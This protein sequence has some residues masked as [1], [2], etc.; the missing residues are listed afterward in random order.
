MASNQEIKLK[1]LRHCRAVLELRRKIT[2]QVS[3]RGVLPVWK[4]LETTLHQHCSAMRAELEAMDHSLVSSM[5]NQILDTFT[6]PKEHLEK[7]IKFALEMS[8]AQASPITEEDIL[9]DLQ[10]LVVAFHNHTDHLLRVACIV[11]AWCTN[12]KSTDD[13]ENS[14]GHLKLIRASIVP[15]LAELCNSSQRAVGL[16]KLQTLYQTW[17][18]MTES[19]LV[20]FDD[21]FNLQQF[22]DVCVHRIEH[23]REQCERTLKSQQP[24]Q[25]SQHGDD[26]CAQANL[27]VQLISKYVERNQ[28]PIFRNGL[29]ALVK[30]IE[31]SIEQ[32]RKSKSCCQENPFDVTLGTL[33]LENIQHVTESV[34]NVR[35]GVDGSN[36]PD[37]L[38]PLR[39]HVRSQPKRCENPELGMLPLSH[40]GSNKQ[41]QAE[42][43][44]QFLEYLS[45]ALPPGD[46]PC[47]ETPLVRSSAPD[48]L[49]VNYNLMPV[50]RDIMAAAKKNDIKAVNSASSDLFE[51]SDIYIE[52][53]K[54]ALQIAHLQESCKLRKYA[55][56]QKQTSKFIHVCRGGAINSDLHVDQLLKIA[57]VLSDELAEITKSLVMVAG[58]WGGFCQQLF[59]TKATADFPSRIQIFKETNQNLSAVV[60]Q[61]GEVPHVDFGKQ[62]NT[63]PGIHETFLE[64][65]TKLAR[66]ETNAKHVLQTA[67]SYNDNPWC[68]GRI[69]ILE[70][71]C[72]L[73]SVCVQQLLKSL[74]KFTGED[75]Q[76][77][78]GSKQK[79]LA[80]ILESSLR[81]QETAKMSTQCCIDQTLKLRIN[82]LREQI[83]H[84]TQ[85]LLQT[86]EGCDMSI[87]SSINPVRMELLQRQIFLKVKA[88]MKMLQSTN[89]EYIGALQGIIDLVAAGGTAHGVDK[90][91]NIKVFEKHSN[92]INENI[93]RA[94]TSLKQ[95]FGTL[96]DL[97]SQESF[98]SMV[99]HLALLMSD[100]LGRARNILSGNHQAGTDMLKN[101]VSDWSARAHFL[102][103]RLEA[104]EGTDQGLLDLIKQCLQKSEAPSVLNADKTS[105]FH[106]EDQAA[107]KEVIKKDKK[108]QES[109]HSPSISEKDRQK[110]KSE[111]HKCF[112]EPLEVLKSSDMELPFEDQAVC[113]KDEAESEHDAWHPIVQVTKEMDKQ[114]SY[115]VQYLTKEGPIQVPLVYIFDVHANVIPPDI[116]F[117]HQKIILKKKIRDD[118]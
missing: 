100:F 18:R 108:T 113:V 65:Q 83:E 76:P 81:I 37:I 60:Y 75:I 71:K 82:Q 106:T 102:V 91:H 47:K 109:S 29:L 22:L 66:V 72:I 88:L 2:S 49:F 9:K 61:A 80:S 99:D 53:A 10:P 1:L 52:A 87:M 116:G 33:F 101:M 63:F 38:S 31:Q 57:I 5:L 117:H 48:D 14:M 42:D 98:I 114:M 64:I 11:L 43:N 23:N 90:E 79:R 59:C 74:D 112:D 25:F 68:T 16:E 41:D 44:N 62:I 3:A 56:I 84:L 46:C 7:L 20:S 17:T 69:D 86:T 103:T 70:A 19:L 104:V 78:T 95:T 39:E 58:I 6:H 40:V 94:K 32:A 8:V 30:Q 93:Q 118:L 96:I 27:V 26:L 111:R 36:H 92:Q 55:R 97:K 89:K 21:V 34:C 54:E 45:K 110:T 85:D 15:L 107:M 51:F 4:L 73:W 77:T 13:I 12:G 24:E 105:L 50:V 35:S 67:M 115:L 28:D